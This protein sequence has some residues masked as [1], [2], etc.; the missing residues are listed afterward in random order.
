MKSV[1][2]YG[3]F[4]DKDLLKEKGF[5]PQNI[6]RAYLKGYQLEIG[7]RATLAPHK[8]ACSYGTVMELD[9]NELQNL[10]GSDGV[11]DYVPQ[12]VQA[13]T[14]VGE[15]LEA[16]SYIY[17]WKRSQEVI[18]SFYAIKLAVGIA[19]TGTAPRAASVPAAGSSAPG[20][21]FGKRGRLPEPRA[22]RRIELALQAF[23]V[24][25]QPIAL[26]LQARHVVMQTRE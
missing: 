14:M 2:F 26:T 21:I 11:E 15:P 6:K 3:L 13:N 24:P 22:P 1:F 4:M 25:L 18:A 5:N 16:V 10:Y 20:P 9:S 19:C 23:G 8:G 17:Q 7:E 12:T